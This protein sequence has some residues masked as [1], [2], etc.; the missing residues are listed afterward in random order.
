MTLSSYI[1]QR[2]LRN[3]TLV[4]VVIAGVAALLASIENTRIAAAN[5][6]TLL[7][8][9][10]LTLFQLPDIL[11]QT[12]P[13]IVML[14]A[15]ATFLGLSRNSEM[16]VVRASGVSA[17]QMLFLPALAAATLGVVAVTVVNPIVAYATVRAEETK[18][19]IQ[20]RDIS[21]LSVSAQ[22]LWLRQ[23]LETGQTVIQA[24]RV[25]EDGALLSGVRLHQ[26]DIDNRLVA[27]IEAQSA[28]LV[29][30]AWLLR[31]V[32]RW[33]LTERRQG[34]E[35]L[36]EE[37]V[38]LSLP[39]NLTRA[40]I[41]DSFATP[42]AIEIWA[43]PGFIRSLE[44]AGF[45]ATPH[46]VFFHSELARPALFIAMVLI[47]AG[48]SLRHVRFGQTGVMILLAI[49]AGFV[50]YFFKDIAETLGGTGAI[51]IL[52]AAWSPPAAAILLATALLLHLEDG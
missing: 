41:L 28:Q 36:P 52:L 11:S 17:L 12:L 1:T 50:L 35:G 16:V 33:D 46:K 29:E 23:G 13:L 3:V 40:Q 47:G 8:A 25:S 31:G 2:F 18:A 49:F 20:Q 27:R 32:R 37:L 39:T 14:G 15:L 48:F 45:T 44:R 10:A 5:N 30:N 24:G 38:Q 19:V 4:L 26:F 42:A 22:G 51:P 43:L 21:I 34:A 6:A 7:E 9:G